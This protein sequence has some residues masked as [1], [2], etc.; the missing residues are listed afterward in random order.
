MPPTETNRNL[1]KAML[2]FEHR[3]HG[4]A[5]STQIQLRCT[6]EE[7]HFLTLLTALNQSRPLPEEPFEAD[8]ADE[9]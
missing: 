8:Q 3:C 7:K 2:T 4:A 6:G 9:K 5:D 1:N